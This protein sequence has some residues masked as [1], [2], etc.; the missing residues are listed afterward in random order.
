MKVFYRPWN[1]DKREL[2]LRNHPTERGESPPTRNGVAR[3]MPCPSYGVVS[4]QQ[5]E[6]IWIANDSQSRWRLDVLQVSLSNR[7]WWA[8][9][10]RHPTHGYGIYRLGVEMVFHLLWQEKWLRHRD[11]FYRTE[12]CRKISVAD[13]MQL[14][15]QSKV[16]KSPSPR[17]M[18]MQKSTHHSQ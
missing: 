10:C 2:L 9:T 7:N 6:L 17:S 3:E 4:L 14:S 15:T 16:N 13:T 11:E 8:P 5:T 1:R 12:C 18:S